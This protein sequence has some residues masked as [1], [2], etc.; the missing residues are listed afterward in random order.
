M[1]DEIIKALRAT[2]ERLAQDAGLD[3]KR[4]IQNIQHEEA[5][6]TADGRVVLQAP[7][8]KRAHTD[9]Q[10]IRFANN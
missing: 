3:I 1:N 2:K 7:V 5:C 10:K 8:N 4:L 9:F 6:S